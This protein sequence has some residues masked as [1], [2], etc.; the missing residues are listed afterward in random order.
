MITTHARIAT[1]LA[2]GLALAALAAPLEATALAPPCVALAQDTSDAADE[3]PESEPASPRDLLERG[4][5]AENHEHDLGA[6]KDLFERALAAARAEQDTALVAEIEAALRAVRVRLG[7]LEEEPPT[8]DPEQLASVV[9]LLIDVAREDHRTETAKK[10]IADL[11]LYGGTAIEL[12]ERSIQA[13]AGT[14]IHA[15]PQIAAFQANP[16]FA[17]R[18]LGTIG[19][20]RA[21]AALLGALS[22]ADPQ[23]RLAAV[24]WAPTDLVD[25]FVAASDD[26]VDTIRE[27]ARIRLIQHAA[28][29]RG[30][31][32]ERDDVAEALRHAFLEGSSDA[33]SLLSGNRPRMTL[34]LLSRPLD[35]PERQALRGRPSFD[36]EPDLAL[37]EYAAEIAFE[38]TTEAQVDY[39]AGIVGAFQSYWSN[40]SNE[41]DYGTYRAESRRI[42]RDA[43]S[44]GSIRL[45]DLTS[46]DEL[47]SD[48]RIAFENGL[49]FDTE[50]DEYLAGTVRTIGTQAPR[51]DRNRSWVRGD[52]P[53]F[54]AYRALF[55]LLAEQI[56]WSADVPP[57][58]AARRVFETLSELSAPGQSNSEPAGALAVW[59]RLS[60]DARLHLGDPD[61]LVRAVDRCMRDDYPFS[62]RQRQQ[63]VAL[64]EW[65]I[66]RGDAN[67]I[68]NTL[69][70]MGIAGDPAAIGR[71]LELCIERRRELGRGLHDLAGPFGTLVERASR[72]EP[73][74]TTTTLVELFA[75]R[76][77]GPH[78]DEERH[79]LLDAGIDAVAPTRA[80]F[81]RAVLDRGLDPSLEVELADTL[82]PI[83][84]TREDLDLLVEVY[85]LLPVEQRKRRVDIVARL[86]ATLHEPGLDLIGRALRDSDKALRDAARAALEE[87]KKQRE[88]LEEFERW[89]RAK[90]EAAETTDALV[91]LLASDDRDVVLGAVEALGAVRAKTALPKL[92]ELLARDD[93]ELKKAVRA[94]I[95]RIGDEG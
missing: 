10:V 52:A 86:G 58:T 55:E 41:A 22:S 40:R 44:V 91:A 66:E 53:S 9:Q 64:G 95:A 2:T 90:D 27:R 62:D 68:Y 94:A 25:V 79:L 85:D 32:L 78:G 76:D 46:I 17:A 82:T 19:T 72:N 15:H 18:A 83:A 61:D 23:V 51:R 6:A 11:A 47:T 3:D 69:P 1:A 92:V 49:A 31:I 12:L 63:I 29:T 87:F 88:A 89:K 8:P 5:Y 45:L 48:L 57:L 71:A 37:L 75:S 56:D 54:D 93:E 26:D 13:P 28:S 65:S 38:P 50:I 14:P 39:V 43:P 42:F 81:V 33:G 35:L 34:E 74:A 20:P 60:A 77:D 4:H 36:E 24:T 73:D 80:A 84:T 7:E 30:R 67:M 59:S 70:L 21:R 16:L